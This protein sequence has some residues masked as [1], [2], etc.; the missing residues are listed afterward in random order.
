MANVSSPT[1]LTAVPSANKPTSFNSTRLPASIDCFIA[2]ASNVSTPITLISGRT[3]LINA[4]IPAAKPPPPIATK[5]A[6]IGLW[7]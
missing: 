7:Y 1:S 2:Q 6:S 4:A 5:I 3:F